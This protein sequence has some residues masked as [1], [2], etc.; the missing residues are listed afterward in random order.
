MNRSSDI[1]DYLA[2]SDETN[3]V[4]L[5]PN[6]PPVVHDAGDL[7][8]VLNFVLTAE[9]VMDTFAGLRAQCTSS[10]QGRSVA[11]HPAPPMQACSHSACVGSGVSAS[12]FSPSAGAKS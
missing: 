8:V 4:I 12:A 10:S 3:S 9:D 2:G 5:A 6:A 1:L 7:R 11:I